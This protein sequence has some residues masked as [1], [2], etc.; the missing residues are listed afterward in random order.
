MNDAPAAI[1]P[2]ESARRPRSRQWLE[3]EVHNRNLRMRFVYGA[4][5]TSRH[6]VELWCGDACV[7]R[8]PMP[9]IM[10]QADDL[11]LVSRPV[12]V[13]GPNCLDALSGVLGLTDAERALFRTRREDAETLV[14]EAAKEQRGRLETP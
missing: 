12:E 11:T 10:T 1:V 7:A 14:T 3:A 2:I 5:P 9:T 6:Y 4:T 8:D 13:P